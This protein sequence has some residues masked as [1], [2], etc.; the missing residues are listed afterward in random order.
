MKAFSYCFSLIRKQSLIEIHQVLTVACPEAAH[1]CSV[2]STFI[3]NSGAVAAL[4]ISRKVTYLINDANKT[5][6][7]S[8]IYYTTKDPTS[9][10]T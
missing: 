2:F 10:M 8:F 7:T 5:V 4:K 3:C 6:F 1:G 9:A